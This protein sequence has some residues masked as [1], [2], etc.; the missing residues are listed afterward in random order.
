MPDC[1]VT[2]LRGRKVGK[3]VLPSLAYIQHPR[4][5]ISTNHQERY[6]A[7]DTSWGCPRTA[8]DLVGGTCAIWTP[9]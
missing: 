3:L 8:R 9:L 1:R 7:E 4:G 2:I 6:E 5:T